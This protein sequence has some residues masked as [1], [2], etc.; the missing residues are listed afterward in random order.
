[1]A[2]TVTREHKAA[3]QRGRTIGAAV[4]AYLKAIGKPK[5]RGRKISLKELQHRHAAAV[6]EADA[7][8]GVKRLQLIQK[9]EDLQARIDAETGDGDIDIDALEVAFVDVAA[10]YGQSKGIS[11][12][13]WRE[14]G[15]P[16]AVLKKAGIRR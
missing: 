11:Y 5:R 13:S 2:R 1:M 16:A 12:G 6:A 3:M 14:A 4:D 7:A 8:E 9:A 15:V 10:E